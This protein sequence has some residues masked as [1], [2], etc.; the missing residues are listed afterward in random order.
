MPLAVSR[1]LPTDQISMPNRTSLTRV[2]G[3]GSAN[4]HT[5]TQRSCERGRV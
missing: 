4:Y 1:R 3:I 5:A 2:F